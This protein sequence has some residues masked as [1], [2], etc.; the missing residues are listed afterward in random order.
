MA[1][2]AVYSLI[3]LTLILVD[4]EWDDWQ[5]GVCDKTCG[6]GLLTKTRI[7]KVNEQNGGEECT[8]RSNVTESCNIQ[9]CPGKIIVITQEN[10][11]LTT[12]D[13]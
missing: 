3:S 4:C 2:R 10:C 1:K 9:E 11:E 5:V 13:C 8:G 7:P 12:D 6:G